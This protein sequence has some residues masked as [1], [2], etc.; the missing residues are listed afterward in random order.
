MPPVMKPTI[1]SLILCLS[2]LLMAQEKPSEPFPRTRLAGSIREGKT[3]INLEFGI[4]QFEDGKK[5]EGRLQIWDLSCSSPD[6]Y[7]QQP[8]RFNTWCS[9]ERIVMDK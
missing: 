2:P 4:E 3:H 1:L 7:S 5:T 9:L 6:V 8:S